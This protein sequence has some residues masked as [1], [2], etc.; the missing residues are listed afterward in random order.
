MRLYRGCHIPNTGT[1]LAHRLVIYFCS[2]AMP[3]TFVYDVFLS[4]NSKDK[5][6]RRLAELLKVCEIG[7]FIADSN[8]TPEDRVLRTEDQNARRL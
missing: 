4:Q 6:R 8:L 1:L 5:P 3:E 2:N 7:A